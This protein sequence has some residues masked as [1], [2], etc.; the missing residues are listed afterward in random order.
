MRKYTYV[1]C[2]SC[3]ETI[4]GVEEYDPDDFATLY[5]K[6]CLNED[7]NL[8]QFEAILDRAANEIQKCGKV[9]Y[10]EA[11]NI[12]RD[13]LLKMP[14]WKEIGASWELPAKG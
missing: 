7:G 1:S 12:A 8:H 3:G 5:C 14:A 10:E 4:S 13:R 11:R 2:Q 6:K 9:T